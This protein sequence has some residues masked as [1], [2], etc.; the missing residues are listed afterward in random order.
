MI[1]IYIVWNNIKVLQIN[2]YW[3]LNI[4]FLL[5]FGLIPIRTNSCI[6]VYE[7][8]KGISIFQL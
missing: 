2:E 7:L 3:Y 8:D 6:L 1:C 4:N 5:S